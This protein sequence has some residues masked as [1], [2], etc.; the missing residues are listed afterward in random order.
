MNAKAEIP[1]LD[2][3]GLLERGIAFEMTE[4]LAASAAYGG[5]REPHRHPFYEIAIV[6]ESD[7]RHIID[8]ASYDNI[9]NK[10]FVM[11]PGQVHHWEG[12]TAIS[13]TLLRFGDEFLLES[14][15]S[16]N[17]VWEMNLIREMAG[18][19]VGLTPDA[20][21]ELMDLIETMYGE[22]ARMN[23]EYA[24]ILRACLNILIIRLFRLHKGAARSESRIQAYSTLCDEFQ[25]LVAKDSSERRKPV[26]HY[27][28]QLRVSMGYLSDQVKRQTGLTPG[29]VIRKAI[30]QEAKRMI[31]NTGL[32]MAEIAESMGFNDGSYFCR[33]FKK[34]AGLSPIQFRQACASMNLRRFG[35]GL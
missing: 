31:A 17:A 18:G 28:E 5:A 20:R 12:V 7:G 23:E 1:V 19:A 22:Y 25:R 35:R 6:L 21:L 11:C 24:S 14:S 13:G 8:C 9:V 16:V 27:A 15:F 10:V 2:S 30:V 29:E 32:S 3:E 33:L 4:D 34:E 26:R